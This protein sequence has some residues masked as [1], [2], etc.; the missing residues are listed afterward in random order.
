[1]NYDVSFNTDFRR[2]SYKG[3]YV[4]L[5]GID[6]SGKTTQAKRLVSYIQKKGKKS[7]YTKEPTDE[8]TGRL[9]RKV[10]LGKISVPPV[11]FQYLFA[12][13]RAV[14]QV[15][16]EK[17]L[18][19][20]LIVVGDRYFWSSAVYGMLDRG[21]SISEKDKDLLLVA[22]SI[23]SMYHRFILPDYTFYLR[24]SVDKAIKRL[25]DNGKAEEIYEKRD[26]LER[27]VRG[28]E[29]L[30]KKFSREITVVDGEGSVE[31]VNKEVVKLL[32]L[33]KLPR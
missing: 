18:K 10:L 20:G 8:V 21:I 3:V 5:E 27:I 19:E 4:V 12:A 23:L 14:H 29:W 1:M 32:R 16:L 15:N 33:L 17:Y 13:D 6:G 7:I 25:R 26:K 22:F 30:A 31:E 11:A 28:Y 24:V 9:I 2:N